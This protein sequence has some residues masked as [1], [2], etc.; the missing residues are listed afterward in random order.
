MDTEGSGEVGYSADEWADRLGAAL[1]R[2]DHDELRGLITEM[3]GE[4]RGEARHLSRHGRAPLLERLTEHARRLLS[5]DPTEIEALEAELVEERRILRDFKSRYTGSYLPAVLRPFLES[6][7]VFVGP[8]EGGAQFDGFDKYGGQTV[9]RRREAVTLYTRSEAG[10][11]ED[12]DYVPPNFFSAFDGAYGEF[13]VRR[14]YRTVLPRGA[15]TECIL[16]HVRE[17]VPDLGDLR[18]VRIDDVQNRPT[19]DA[20]VSTAEGARRLRK[21]A[22]AEHTPLGRLSTRILERLGLAV[23]S[24]DA[25]LDGFGVLDLVVVV[26][27]P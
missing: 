9:G 7:C 26:R 15:G 24:M 17:L 12:A 10:A 8:T 25:H 22:E 18:R 19:Y 14:A 27:H 16:E 1:D 11:G 2:G 3:R 20:H 6:C 21:S 23:E 5:S 4:M 13:V